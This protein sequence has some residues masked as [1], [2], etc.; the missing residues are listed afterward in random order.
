MQPVAVQPI[1]PGS[2][3]PLTSPVPAVPPATP[4]KTIGP[5]AAPATTT[6]NV[7]ASSVVPAVAPAPLV[8][9]APPQ[10]PVKRGLL[11]LASPSAIGV[12]QQFYV[13]VKVADAQGL[14]GAS[15]A[16]T[17][18]PNLADFVSVSEGN[19]LKK[20]GQKTVFS[21]NVANGSV[22]INQSRPVEG[23]GVTGAGSLASALF[24]TKSKGAA[25][26]GFRNVVFTG[27]DGNPLEMLPFSTAVD[28]R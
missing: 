7:S 3:T 16:L 6:P 19:F 9:P 17:Y 8:L 13:D 5:V 23:G 25:S 18:D 10:Q 20:G 12:G 4:S 26:F 27:I 14:A 2:Q 22:T 1:A 21:S 15:Y 11:Q 24:K 28:V